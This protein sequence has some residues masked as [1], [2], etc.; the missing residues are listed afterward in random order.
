M[1]TRIADFSYRRRWFVVGFWIVALVGA[2]VA[3]ASFGGEWKGGA[4]LDGTDSQRAYDLIEAKVPA[5]SGSS[6]SV[7][8]AVEGGVNS[9]QTSIEKYLDSVKQIKGVVSV[10]SP[11]STEG[12]ISEAG[13][14]AFATVDFTQDANFDVA[15]ELQAKATALKRD[16]VTAEFSGFQF[17]EGELPASEIFGL[18]A[19]AIILMIAFGSIVAAGLPLIT[20][21]VGIGIGLASV[22]LWAAVVDTP[23]FTVQVASMIGIG[24][25]IDYALFIV[26]RFREAKGR[27]LDVRGATLEAAGTAGRA[28][29]FAGLTVMVSLLGMILMRLKFLN[30]LAI[31]SS[32]AVLV[33]VLAAITLLPAL[34]AIAGKRI[35]PVIAHTNA[36]RSMW[37]GWSRLLQRRAW[38][39]ATIGMVLLLALSAP[40]LFIR[41]GEADAGSAPKTQTVR[42]A[43][44]LLSKGFTPG[45]ESPFL[46]AIDTPDEGARTA[47]D[48]IASA[49][50]STPGIALVTNPQATEDGSAAIITA[51]A[52]TSPQDRKTDSLLH[53][54]R[55]DVLPT[56]VSGTNAKAYVGGAAASNSDF[57]TFIGQRLP[58]FIGA[59]LFISFLLMMA[60]FRSVLVPLKAVILNLLSIGAAYG[61]MVAVFQWGWAGSLFGV[62]QGAPIAPWAPMMLFAIVF[63]LSMDY[64]VFLLSKIRERYDQT[65]DNSSAVAEGVAATARVITAAAAIMVFVFGFFVFGSSRDIKLIG[66]GLATAVLIDAT[67]VRLVLVPAS[68]ELLGDRNW[69]LPRWLDRVLPHLDVEGGGAPSTSPAGGAVSAPR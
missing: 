27:G 59:V 54:L 33:A 11:F 43:H 63:G 60:M 53:H 57:A 22:G 58:Y 32:T 55:N 48:R 3:N 35:K 68:M 28:V 24:V 64:E 42:R 39:A 29:V 62:D 69:W 40:T 21:I 19:A 47:V 17:A 13:D 30:G 31:G 5:K 61:V 26:T 4:R 8:F 56:A 10:G 52:T 66:L 18:I 2:T 34:L 7:V 44:D 25:G 50:R 46:L 23:D 38:P 36:K 1:L 67:V 15:A 20:A 9:K 49:V 14:I 45:F 12:Q 41:L 6:A 16:G 51:I 37:V 65:G